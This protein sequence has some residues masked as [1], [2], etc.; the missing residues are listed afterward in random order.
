[1]T[2]KLGSLA[3]PLALLSCDGDYQA[4]RRKKKAP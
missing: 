2:S 1:M 4:S 3:R